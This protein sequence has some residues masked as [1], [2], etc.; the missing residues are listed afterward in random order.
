MKKEQYSVYNTLGL[1]FTQDSKRALLH[2]EGGN[3]KKRP[4]YVRKLLLY[5]IKY[6]RIKLLFWTSEKILINFLPK[7]LQRSRAN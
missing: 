2:S 5:K 1:D 6:I 7:K 3:V 4:T